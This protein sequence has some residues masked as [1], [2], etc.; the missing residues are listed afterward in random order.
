MRVILRNSA[1]GVIKSIED[2]A[3]QDRQI[4]PS[5][6]EAIRSGRSIVTLLPGEAF[7][8]GDVEPSFTDLVRAAYYSGEVK[9][10]VEERWGLRG[11]PLD[12]RYSLFPHQRRTLR[13]M[14]DRERISPET[15]H[16]LRGGVVHLQMGLGKTL[17]A[18]SFLLMMPRGKFPTLI[19]ASKTVMLEWKAETAKFFGDRM[20]VLYLHK[21][22]LGKE[23]HSLRRSDV[24]TY[25]VVITT[26]DVCL[27]VCK[28][29]ELH[30]DCLV[31]GS[32][33]SIFLGKVLNIRNRTRQ[34]AD[35]PYL[36]GPAVLY[37]TPWERI[38]CDESQTFSNSSSFT[39]K[40]MMALYGTHMWCLSGTP[41]RNYDTDIWSQFR[42]LGYDGVGTASQWRKQGVFKMYA[43]GLREAILSMDYIDAGIVVPE[44][45]EHT[46]VVPLDPEESSHYARL[47]E[48]TRLMLL[49]AS[50][51]TCLLTMFTRLRQCCISPTLA[52]L[53]DAPSSKLKA[54]IDL[55]GRLDGKVVVFSMFT[56]CLD[57]LADLIEERMPHYS[58][59]QVDGRTVGG[60]RQRRINAFRTR[61]RIRAFLC[62]YKTGG[63]GLNLIEAANCICIEPWWSPYIH[64]QAHSRIWR[65]G[66]THPVNV[67]NFVAKS[68]IEES[69]I[70]IYHREK[71]R[72]E[73]EFLSGDVSVGRVCPDVETLRH[74]LEW[75]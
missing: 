14:R 23:Y 33:G 66:Q 25:D 45:R 64:R 70:G 6:G 52:A 5:I 42:F 18:L 13:W 15:I 28:R 49:N 4:H 34:Q 20:R 73:D 54:V 38:F 53:D 47:L 62:T 16:G 60:E 35:K 43:H 68:T 50:H 57:L 59:V 3:F 9:K 29:Q 67:Y 55:L 19:V 56:S 26:Y 46:I 8:P 24:V 17:T 69:I 37:G 41:V 40:A 36:R 12:A 31:R 58:F 72:V 51:Y 27:T 74:I 7:D 61:K 39:F 32:K 71:M 10:A 75:E 2:M 1:G 22:S 30:E 21:D 11:L 44:K 65:M 48:Q 63:Q